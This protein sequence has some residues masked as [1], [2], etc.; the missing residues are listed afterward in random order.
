MDVTELMFTYK[1]ALIAQTQEENLGMLLFG[2]KLFPAWG[3]NFRSISKTFVLKTWQL[4]I[5]LG[6]SIKLRRATEVAQAQL[7]GQLQELI[8]NSPSRIPRDGSGARVSKRTSLFDVDEPP[9]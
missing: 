4:M 6:R 8:A 7:P 3:G 5:Q 2:A 9:E 1:K